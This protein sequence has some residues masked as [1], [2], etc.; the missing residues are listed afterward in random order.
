MSFNC[1]S[2]PR[3]KEFLFSVAHGWGNE[4]LARSTHDHL[5]VGWRTRSRTDLNIIFLGGSW[6][7]LFKRIKHIPSLVHILFIKCE[8]YD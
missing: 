4:H 8:P 2:N 1:F 6:L 7:L 3:R 5:L